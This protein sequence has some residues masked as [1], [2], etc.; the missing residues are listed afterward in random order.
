[1]P[2]GEKLKA[3]AT[4]STTT[5]EFQKL[6]CLVLVLYQ[7]PPIAKLL[8][9]GKKGGSFWLLIKIDL[10]KCFDLQNKVF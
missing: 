10:E 5:C 4:G 3:K 1:M 7:N 6:L 8:S 9:C 2:K